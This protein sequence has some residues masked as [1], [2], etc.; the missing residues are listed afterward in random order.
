MCLPTAITDK[1][2]LRFNFNE[3]S[4]IIANFDLKCPKILT[5]PGPKGF[6]V[7]Y[8][9]MIE[10][11]EHWQ[12]SLATTT[13]DFKRAFEHLDREAL[14]QKPQA[15][16]WSI[17]ENIQHL[18]VINSS[19]FPI[20][21]QVEEGSYQKPFIGNFGFLTKAIGNMILK[22]VDPENPKKINTIPVWKPEKYEEKEQEK[23]LEAFEA[24]Q[25]EFSDWIVR[26]K[27]A[28]EKGQVIHSP[29]NRLIAYPL[30]MAMDIITTHE[31]RHLAQAKR[32]L[33]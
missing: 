14:Y 3:L 9:K 6:K 8:S 28:L 18:M 21:K 2:N 25:Q 7:T 22:S 4:I 33:K 32:V 29:A 15:G 30:E 17:A 24:H 10:K 27:P 19:Y 16:T 13:A 12:S 31:K 20:F 5:G 23:L 1:L 26:L 11:I